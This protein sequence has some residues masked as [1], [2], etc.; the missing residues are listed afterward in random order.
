MPRAVKRRDPRLTVHLSGGDLAIIER[1]AALLGRPRADFVR[2]AAVRA[3]EDAVMEPTTVR[4][5]PTG[6]KAFLAAVSAPATPVPEMVDV[7]RHAPPWE[8]GSPKTKR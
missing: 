6:F 7:L 2:D 5:S 3:A 1:A 8:A 4:M